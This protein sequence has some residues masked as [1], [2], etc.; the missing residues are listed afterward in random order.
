MDEENE[1]VVDAES[2]EVST[3]QEVQEEVKPAEKTY[4]Q[5]DIDDMKA[6]WE[7]NFQK[8]LDKAIARKMSD[9]DEE[10]FK[11]DQLINVLKELRNFCNWVF[12]FFHHSNKF[13]LQINM[14]YFH[15]LFLENYLS[16]F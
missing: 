15:I 2:T 8:K 11:K 3:E 16:F 4:T 9:Y 14:D 12:I 1:E 5:A 10:S 13:N 6:K 7:G